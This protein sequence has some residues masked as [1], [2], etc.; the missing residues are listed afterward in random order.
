VV[1][2]R[3]SLRFVLNVIK[4]VRS[5]ERP[6]RVLCREP[7][8][9]RTL[10]TSV[11]NLRGGYLSPVVTGLLPNRAIAISA[12]SEAM[13][14]THMGRL[15]RGADRDGLALVAEGDLLI[16]SPLAHAR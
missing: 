9:S 10:G 8:E 15:R 12:R 16:A 3:H 5:P 13:A 1:I 2:S 11:N 7:S 14:V 4:Q 6:Y